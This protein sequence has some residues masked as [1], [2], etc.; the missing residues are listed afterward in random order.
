IILKNHETTGDGLV[1][2]LFMLKVM[3]DT[4]KSMLELK[5][6]LNI[7]PQLLVNVKVTDKNAVLDDAEVQAAIEKVNADL[8][9]NGRLLVRPSGTEPLLR[10]MAE[11]ETDEIC[12]KEVNLIANIIREKYGAN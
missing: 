9:G 12:E 2:A 7:Y 8:D 4:G 5:E 3:Q 10:V 6:G 11:A 1:T